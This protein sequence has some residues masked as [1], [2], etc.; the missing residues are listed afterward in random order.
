MLAVRLIIYDN[1]SV[2]MR[3]MSYAQ[4]VLGRPSRRDRIW[5]ARLFSRTRQTC[6]P[7]ISQL[8]FLSGRPNL[9]SEMA[10]WAGRTVWPRCSSATWRQAGISQTYRYLRA[11]PEYQIEVISGDPGSRRSRW[12]WFR[13]YYL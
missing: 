5:M 8:R 11:D 6:K 9:W 1:F 3:N 12:W 7:R 10:R 2:M 4:E 13:A